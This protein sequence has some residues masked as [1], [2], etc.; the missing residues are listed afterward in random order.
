MA[1]QKFEATVLQ[2]RNEIFVKMVGPE[3]VCVDA[4]ARVY[5]LLCVGYANGFV[6]I[7]LRGNNWTTILFSLFCKDRAYKFWTHSD[8]V[9]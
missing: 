4:V 9:R 8:R 5:W 7:V 2:K 3:A 1:C 6:A